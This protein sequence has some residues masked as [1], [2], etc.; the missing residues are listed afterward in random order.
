MHR[1]FRRLFLTN[2]TDIEIIFYLHSTSFT[3]HY[4]TTVYLSVLVSR[5]DARQVSNTVGFGVQIHLS[6]FFF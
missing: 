1:I 2:N 4:W 5:H 6:S 3:F